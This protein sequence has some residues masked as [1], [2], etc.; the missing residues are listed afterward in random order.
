MLCS[1]EWKT[2]HVRPEDEGGVADYYD[3]A[4]ALRYCKSNAMRKIQQR[5]TLRAV[6]LA[7]FPLGSKI[8]DAGCG[9]G[10]S[11]QVL[12]Q[13]GYEV[14]PFDLLP[15]FVAKCREKGFNARQGDIRRFPFKGEFDGIV[16][17][18]ALQW[19]SCRGMRE[20]EKVAEQFWSHL[21][22]KGNAVVQFYPKSEAELMSVARVFRKRGFHTRVI[23]DNVH[24]PRKRKVFIMLGKTIA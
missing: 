16:S 6:Q 18:S 9:P 10:F 20:V 2:F 8:I 3:E 4:E 22:K 19:V 7:L 1:P 11:S 24:N 23:T 17:I 21:K 14:Y 15:A 13:I 5:L 12:R